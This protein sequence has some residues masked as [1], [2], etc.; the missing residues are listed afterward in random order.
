MVSSISSE[1][2]R[3]RPVAA[4]ISA[5]ETA[6]RN[7][8]LVPPPQP[9]AAPP[10][11][12]E[13]INRVRAQA[14]MAV[15]ALEQLNDLVARFAQEDRP[16]QVQAGQTPAGQASSG[17]AN[18]GQAPVAPK[19]EFPWPGFPAAPVPRPDQD[20]RARPVSGILGQ[21]SA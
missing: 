16:T 5:A 11:A 2:Y 1:P 21:L 3:P 20:G 4:A 12:Q 18:G 7:A 8:Q 10:T 13:I 9:P 17:Q 15:R 6:A 14:E 19:R